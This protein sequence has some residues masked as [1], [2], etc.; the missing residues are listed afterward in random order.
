M[1]LPDEPPN[2]GMHPTA[3]T[4][5]F[6]NLNRSGRRVMPSVGRLVAGHGEQRF[7]GRIA[8]GKEVASSVAGVVRFP[9]CWRVSRVVGAA[10]SAL[11][12]TWVAAQQAHAP[13]RGHDSCHILPDRPRGG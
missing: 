12:Q 11:S 10:R 3:D 13:D 1:S 2:N 8:G 5:D 9:S 4:T 7:A 6:I